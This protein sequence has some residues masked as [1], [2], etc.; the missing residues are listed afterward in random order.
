MLYMFVPL[1]IS[2]WFVVVLFVL[3]LCQAAKTGD[4]PI[5]HQQP[6]RSVAPDTLVPETLVPA[7]AV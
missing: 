4:D 6:Y 5:I 2:L 3:A 7:F 1:V